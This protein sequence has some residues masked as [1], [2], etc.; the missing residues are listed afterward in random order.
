VEISWL[1]Y[2]IANTELA[3]NNIYDVMADIIWECTFSGYDTK[4]V[5]K[6]RRKLNEAIKEAEAIKNDKKEAKKAAKR[7][8]K[9]RLKNA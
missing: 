9:K 6:K 8:K 4:T 5:K 1:G 3:V 2:F 7:G